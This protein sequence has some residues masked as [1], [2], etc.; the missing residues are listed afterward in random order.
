[1]LPVLWKLPE[2]NAGIAVTGIKPMAD[3]SL[4]RDFTLYFLL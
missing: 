1:M 4:K 3:N 2:A